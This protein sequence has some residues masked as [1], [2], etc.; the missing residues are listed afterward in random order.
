MDGQHDRD[1]EILETL[2]HKLRTGALN[3]RQFIQAA[4]L[5]GVGGALAACVPPTAPAGTGAPAATAAG[6]PTGTVVDKL[7]VRFKTKEPFGPFLLQLTVTDVVSAADVKKG[8]EPMK[9]APNGTGPFRVVTDEKDRKVMEAFSGYWR[10][11]P[12]IK[13]LTWEFIQDSQT[14]LSALL[15]GQAQVIDRVP[16]E[17]FQALKGS[18]NLVLTSVTGLENVNLW[19]RQDRPPFDANPK[20]RQALAWSIDREALTKNVV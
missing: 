6:A 8:V 18:P 1:E 3:R 5:L 2:T 7:T 11:A 4:A 19:I 13:T 20:L 14:R 17:H 10:G 12:R 16:P 15:A 9:A